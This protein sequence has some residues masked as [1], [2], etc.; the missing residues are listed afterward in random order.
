[1]IDKKSLILELRKNIAKEKKILKELNSLYTHLGKTKDKSEKKLISSQIEHLRKHL[2]ESNDRVS[3]NLRSMV[4]AKP[5]P[6]EQPAKPATVPKTVVQKQTPIEKTIQ[7]KPE[8]VQEQVKPVTEKIIQ[9]KPLGGEVGGLKPIKRKRGKLS[10][11]LKPE[12]LEKETLKR[13]KKKEKKVKE[14]KKKKP[15]K[16]IKSANKL[17]PKL[18]KKLLDKKMFQ[19]LE[20]DLIKANLQ[21]TP[22]TYVSIIFFTTFISIFAALLIF[23]F[24]LFFN[25]GVDI[26]FIT[27][28]TEA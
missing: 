23:I 16:Y 10:K 18:S 14:K 5:L 6:K 8:I 19:T 24:F 3:R 15:S 2:K 1:M 20:R 17:F 13:L 28:S 22:N 11:E 26:P 12:G 4:L 27:R 25:F 7:P 9:E 21:F